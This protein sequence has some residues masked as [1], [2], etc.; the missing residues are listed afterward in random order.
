MKFLVLTF[1]FL[2]SVRAFA[3]LGPGDFFVFPSSAAH[4]F[5]PSAAPGEDC[6]ARIKKVVCLVEPEPSKT[7]GAGIAGADPKSRSCL[8]GGD[9]YAAPF[10]IL[11]DHYPP[12]LQKVF[13]SLGKIYIEKEFFGTAYGG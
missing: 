4:S 13:C 5:I 10:E 7:A 9:A 11:Y 3:S 8:P 2:S 1:A 12:V 6:R